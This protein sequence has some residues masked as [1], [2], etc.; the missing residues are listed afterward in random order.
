M[1]INDFPRDEGTGVALDTLSKVDRHGA[2]LHGRTH[3]QTMLCTCD[4]KHVLRASQA[5]NTLQVLLEIAGYLAQL[6]GRGGSK[7]CSPSFAP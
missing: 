5:S 7:N 6:H 3:K 4:G 1:R 2:E